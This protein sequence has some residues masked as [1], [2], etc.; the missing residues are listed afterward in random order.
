MTACDASEA[1]YHGSPLRLR[2]IRKRSTVTQ[3]RDLARVF[4]HRPSLVSVSDGMG[5][6]RI[7]HDGTTPGFLYRVAEDVRPGDV[8]PHPRSS[9]GCG[10]EWLT[11]REL[12]VTLVGATE[13]V[14]RERLTE[15]EIAALRTRLQ[16]R[17]R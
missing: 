7:K 11:N 16:M 4:S 8:R 9:V 10:K 14:E 1:W 5:A 3:D 13:I 17:D 6:P 15:K 2:A 12:R